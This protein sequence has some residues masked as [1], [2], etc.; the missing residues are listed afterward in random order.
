[1]SGNRGRKSLALTRAPRSRSMSRYSRKLNPSAQKRAKKRGTAARPGQRFFT[2]CL[3]SLFVRKST[4]RRNKSAGKRN[5]A[6]WCARKARTN[7]ST[8]S[9]T[10]VP[11]TSEDEADAR[12]Q[13]ASAKKRA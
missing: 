6:V 9:I 3:R 8:G 10:G 7:R 13:A 5:I 11:R 12:N 1:L 2:V 4:T